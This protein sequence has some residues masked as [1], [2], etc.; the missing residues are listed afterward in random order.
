MF[1]VGGTMTR[2]WQSADESAPDSEKALT[3]PDVRNEHG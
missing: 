2:L 3:V 1:V